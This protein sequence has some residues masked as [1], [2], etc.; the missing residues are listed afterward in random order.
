[1]QITRNTV[2]TIDYKLTSDSGEVLDSSEGGAPLAY[3]HGVGSLIPGLEK[4]LEGKTS[5][6]SL[7]VRIPPEEA[8][9]LRNEE[10]ITEVSRGDLPPDVKIEI[11]MQLQAESDDGIHILTVVGVDDDSVKLD[12]NHPLAGMALNFEVEIKEVREATSEEIEHRHVH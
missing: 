10:M 4:E 1:M 3:V 5:G 6:D 9:G 7:Q 2:A 8:Y 12:A 11:G